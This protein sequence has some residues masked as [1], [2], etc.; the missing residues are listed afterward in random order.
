[1]GRLAGHPRGMP[2]GFLGGSFSWSDVLVM[3]GWGLAGLLR[4]VI[5]RTGQPREGQDGGFDGDYRDG[6]ELAMD[7]QDASQATSSQRL[8]SAAGGETPDG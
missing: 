2:T 3:G 7:G 4:A 1:L 6:I 8:R 5:G